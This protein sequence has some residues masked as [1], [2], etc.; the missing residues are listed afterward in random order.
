MPI[1]KQYKD[2]T[3]E[4]EI[5]DITEELAV[6][7][8]LLACDESRR[9]NEFKLTKRKKEFLCSRIILKHLFNNCIK[10][11]YDEFGKGYIKNSPWEISITH[12]GRFVAVARSKKKIGI[13]IE[14]I[15]EKLNR[16]KHKF[17]SPSE[18]NN[19]DLNNKLLHLTLYWSAKESAYKLVGNEKLIF[20]TE[21]QIEQFIPQE[22]GQFKLKLQSPISKI[23]LSISYQKIKDYVFTYT[24]LE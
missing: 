10:V 15:S 8:D 4:Y 19:I 18:L 20:D 13:D 2:D 9:L 17:S 16:T 12:S 24:S 21:M 23:N 14:S 7:E 11:H 3:I 22:Q 6:L 5:W 1:F